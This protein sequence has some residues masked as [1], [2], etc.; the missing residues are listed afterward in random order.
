[1]RRRV[2]MQRRSSSSGSPA[3]R[4]LQQVKMPRFVVAAGGVAF[5]ITPPKRGSA[6]CDS[7]RSPVAA[8]VRLRRLRLAAHFSHLTRAPGEAD[9]GGGVTCQRN[10]KS[11]KHSPNSRYL[12]PPAG[13]ASADAEL[14]SPKTPF[15]PAPRLMRTGSHESADARPRRRGWQRPVSSPRIARAGSAVSPR[16]P[17]H[18]IHR[19]QKPVSGMQ[20]RDPRPPASQR[21]QE[22]PASRRAAA[23]ACT[24]RQQQPSLGARQL[25][26]SAVRPTSAAA[27]SPDTRQASSHALAHIVGTACS[28]PD[29][30]LHAARR[31]KPSGSAA[32][33]PH[34]T[35]STGV[36][37]SLLPWL[38]AFSSVYVCLARPL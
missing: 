36:H 30:R 34:A 7:P 37:S 29:R 13:L 10:H 17:H 1:M 28:I 9:P 21:T 22:H 14:Q 23:S 27:T 6:R 5:A 20:L 11:G 19:V 38:H 12:R 3:A 26:G 15:R 18:T 35:A 33:K 31:R 2:A 16:S 32:T 24:Q 4:A 25:K 8:L